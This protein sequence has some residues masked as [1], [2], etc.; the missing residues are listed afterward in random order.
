M[1]LTTVGPE[2]TDVSLRGDIGPVVAI[3]DN[4]TF[5]L[6]DWR[7]NNGLD[8]LR[9]IVRYGRVSLMFPNAR[10]HECGADKRPYT[11]DR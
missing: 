10:L 1:V 7:G 5:L 3:E 6:P 8:S 9:N 2:G 11:L 4:H